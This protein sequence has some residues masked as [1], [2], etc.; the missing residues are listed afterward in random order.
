M[1]H[2]LRIFGP[3]VLLV[4]IAFIVT[5]QFV[6]PAP[7]KEV[8]I[9]SGS[10]AGAYHAFAQSYARY[11]AREGVTLNIVNTGGSVENIRLLH[12]GKVDIAFVKGGIKDEGEGEELRSLASLYYEPLWLFHRAGGDFDRLDALSGKSV[13]IGSE[14][15]GTKALVEQLLSLNDLDDEKLNPVMLGGTTAA[16]SLLAGEVDAAFFVSSARSEVIQTLLRSETVKLAS[17]ERADAYAR[18]LRFLTRLELPE[19]LVDLELN[20]PPRDTKML[21]P[22]ANLVVNAELHPAMIDLLLMAA[23]DQHGE[24]DWFES[25]N[26][27]PA[28][29]LLAYPIHD[30]AARFLK[31]GPPF[32]QKYL[33]F[34]AASLID[35]LKV[36]LLPLVLMLLPLIKVMPPVYNWRMRAR[37]YRWYSE[38]DDVDQAL[39]ASESITGEQRENLTRELDRIEADVREVSIPLSFANQLYHLRQHVDLVRKRLADMTS[40]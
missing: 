1:K 2:Q 34:W 13:A 33:P 19:G 12:E 7:P 39:F 18:R 26:Q 17:L 21:A 40:H 25:R 8:T 28:D 30:E 6:K 24:G 23:T 29:T 9:A 20:I 22:A 11:L 5:F 38:L 35:R 10:E 27:F 3:A 37:V 15:S 16:E 36:M 32:L 14:G 31:Q 4:I